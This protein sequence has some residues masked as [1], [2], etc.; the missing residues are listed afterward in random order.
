M[1]E[2]IEQKLRTEALLEEIAVL[3]KEN[4]AQNRRMIS[5][6]ESKKKEDY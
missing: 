6:L 2:K 3:L 5:I 1:E 4:N